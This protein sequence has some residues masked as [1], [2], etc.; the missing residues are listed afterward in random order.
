MKD[1]KRDKSTKIS[2]VAGG[3]PQK[4]AN[5]SKTKNVKQKSDGS[6]SGLEN[7]LYDK[8]LKLKKKIPMWD[9]FFLEEA[10]ES[11]PEY[12]EILDDIGQKLCEKYAWAIPDERALTILKEFSPLIEIGSGK[13]YWA[14]LLQNR[15]VDIIGYDKFTGGKNPDNFTKIK[16]GGP[17]KLLDDVA[18]NR[19]LF[20]CYPDEAESIAIVCLEN[21]TGEY[22]IHVGELMCNTTGTMAG[23]P[24]APYGRTTSAEFQIT[25]P[26][27]FHCLLI[28][29]LSLRYPYSKDC[30][31]V[32]KRTE[33]VAGKDFS[34]DEQE[35]S[36]DE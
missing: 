5:E 31:S 1:Q 11:R 13:G 4:N 17:E 27:Q 8:V 3:K 28:A 9:S 36:E 7:P 10:A 14:K 33:Y 29:N 15:G 2:K 34:G 30:I 21:Y 6:I 25:L 35:D 20:L 32:W 12:W 23:P 19:N 16:E 18:N 24:V 26:E 22:I